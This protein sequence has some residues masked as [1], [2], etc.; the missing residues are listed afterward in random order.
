MAERREREAEK[1]WRREREKTGEMNLVGPATVK[2]GTHKKIE[3]G[4]ESGLD[5][6]TAEGVNSNLPWDPHK[7]QVGI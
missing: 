6:K 5:S 3:S 4:F 1:Q 2:T 7:I